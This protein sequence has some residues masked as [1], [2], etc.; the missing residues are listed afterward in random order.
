MLDSA[1][2]SPI[3]FPHAEPPEP[4][5]AVEIAPGVL[6]FRLALPYALDHVNVFLLEDGAGWVVVDT[7]V[8]DPRTRAA[9]TRLLDEVLA[10]AP[11][12]RVI[13]THFHPDHMG[14]AGWLAQRGAGAPL[15]MSRTEY[16]FAAY[17]RAT[18]G[19]PDRAHARNFYRRGGLDDA[20]IES[21]LG[22]GHAYLGHTSPLPPAFD[23]LRAGDTLAIGGRRFEVLS[24]GGHAPE[25]L[26]LHARE[27]R[28][29]LAAD[30]VLARISPNISVWPNEP[31]AD[32]LGE[33]V[34]SLRSI[35][36]TVPDDVLV[37]AAHN[38]PFF[39][40][41]AR[42]AELLAH[43]A[44]RCDV[45]EQACDSAPRS[46]A[47]L[48][49]MLFRRPLDPQ[50]MGF[51]FGEVLAHVNHMLGAGRLAAE[52]QGAVERFRAA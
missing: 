50:Q 16:L 36:E 25:M 1:S 44:D 14:L 52:E 24:G 22:R 29:F 17:M 12:T 6:W 39:G 45:I 42:I 46:I 27:E 19:S 11:V 43:H 26:M 18:S 48:I 49:P 5:S 28:L 31:A 2:P 30:Q 40:L 33:Y 41:H 21:L 3:R 15:A 34:A 47:E 13:A 51:A 10:G 9:W 37:L 23:R 4:G 35:A 8:D 38:L 7:G 32:P 20:A